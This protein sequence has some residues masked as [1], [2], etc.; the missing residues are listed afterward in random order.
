MRASRPKP[1]PIDSA[2]FQ[3]PLIATPRATGFPQATT[4]YEEVGIDFNRLIYQHPAATFIMK[5]A[6]DVA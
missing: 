1:V 4:D 3:M 2:T 6:R 5:V